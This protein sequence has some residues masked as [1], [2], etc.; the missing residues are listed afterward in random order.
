MKTEYHKNH[1]EF[2]TQEY[3]EKIENPQSFPTST[4]RDPLE[5]AQE[6]I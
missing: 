1:E 5:E 2:F 6:N 3:Q 4:S